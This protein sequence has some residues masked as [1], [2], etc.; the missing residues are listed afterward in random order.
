[1]KSAADLRI[2]DLEPRPCVHGVVHHATYRLAL[3][4]LAKNG[5]PGVDVREADA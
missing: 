2:F 3:N 4:C 1:M 5:D